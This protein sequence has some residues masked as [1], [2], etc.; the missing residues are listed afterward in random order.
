MRGAEPE[1]YW[2]HCRERP[3]VL[4]LGEGTSILGEIPISGCKLL[5]LDIVVSWSHNPL[6]LSCPKFLEHQVFPELPHNA[7]GSF[8]STSENPACYP[9]ACDCTGKKRTIGI[10]G[11]NRFLAEVSH[12][13]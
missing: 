2:L 11:L 8:T 10:A 7:K 9:A 5:H 6:H 3:T 1:D 12:V 13:S 4:G